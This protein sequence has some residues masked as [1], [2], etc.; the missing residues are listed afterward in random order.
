MDPDHD[1]LDSGELCFQPGAMTVVAAHGRP[2]SKKGGH[3]SSRRQ[4]R[5]WQPF[6]D[7]CGRRR[8]DWGPGGRGRLADLTNGRPRCPRPLGG[9][10]SERM[11][12]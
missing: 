3:A 6:N 2:G 8:A 1:E 4:L 5:Y 10:V 11:G 12:V 7:W 9:A